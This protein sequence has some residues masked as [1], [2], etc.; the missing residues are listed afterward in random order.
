MAM[1]R[2]ISGSIL[3]LDPT[4][5]TASDIEEYL[6]EHRIIAR[7]A[8]SG[9]C[10]HVEIA[11]TGRRRRVACLDDEG[12][13][14]PGP[15]L[16]DFIESMDNALRKL[17]ID[18]GGRIAWGDIDLGEVDVEGDDFE[19][20]HSAL[21]TVEQ[22]GLGQNTDIT[23]Q[24]ADEDEIEGDIPD[25]GQGPMLAISD[26]SFAALP[27]AA[28]SLETE[29]A[30]FDA[31][32][33][34]AVIADTVPPQAKSMVGSSSFVVAMSADAAGL[35]SP[36]FVVRTDGVRLTWNWS[37]RLQPLPW[38]AAS[39]PARQFAEA[40]LGV[41]AFTCRVAACV[42][43][44]NVEIVRLALIGH[45]SEAPARLAAAFALPREVADCLGGLLPAR[46]IPGAVVFEPK[47]FGARLQSRVAHAVAGERPSD[48]GL[49]K[50][51]RKVNLER[52][53]LTEVLA[54]VQAG[55]GVVALAGGL[56]SWR[57]AGGKI[58]AVLGG[59]F[60]VNAGA[61]ILTVQWIS[62]ALETE[63]L[64]VPR[65]EGPDVP[66]GGADVLDGA[67]GREAG[68]SG[69]EAGGSGLSA[70][71]PASVAG[72]AAFAAGA[73]TASDPGPTADARGPSRRR[74]TYLAPERGG[75]ALVGSVPEGGAPAGGGAGVTDADAGT[76]RAF[77]E[78]AT[79]GS[80][81]GERGEA[82]GVLGAPGQEPPAFVLSDIEARRTFEEL[83]DDAAEG[84]ECD[85]AGDD[86][87]EPDTRAAAVADEF[88]S[89]PE[90]DRESIEAFWTRARNVARIAPL[91]AVMGQDDLSSLCPPAFSFGNTP[92][93]ADRLA[94]LV[95]AGK[96]T[97]TSGWLASYEAA[98]V[99]L[100]SVGDLSIMCDGR[101][102]PR[103]LLSNTDVKVVRFQQAGREISDAEGEGTFEQWKA[104]HDEFF[105]EECRAQ[106]IEYDPAGSIV[107]EYFE[108][109]YSR[110]DEAVRG[111]DDAAGRVTG[112][113]ET[114][115]GD[116]EN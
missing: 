47:P 54:S 56:R 50:M 75:L 102:R 104:S 74:A 106:G 33:A 71:G 90:A 23:G 3:M 95:L 79:S 16:A 92:E 59:A 64:S 34:T 108:V 109:V 97:A 37:D 55:V 113:E 45:P 63:G 5:A 103:A 19:P 20:E 22:A 57:S 86:C 31:C 84:A 7:A 41:G 98:G 4:L 24:N 65:Q 99:D 53:R 48:M 89:V 17:Q 52:P 107:V 66:G 70:G 39:E 18:I 10:F 49:W 93:L 76:S 88:S 83:G 51:Y 78:Q 6:T 61:R 58:L 81:V 96:K 32:G 38:V 62:R 42:P 29:L 110:E 12:G 87:G 35:D 15:S 46:V 85:T 73:S 116:G 26:V 30:A 68:G 8:A 27:G 21:R 2:P 101:G 1:W 82:A 111:A 91:E 28:A 69:R 9:D 114:P 112:S 25:F 72:G 14:V 36:V 13:V 60:V 100:P 80:A 67:A 43:Q 11:V 40:E 77:A 94:D 44:A 115:R 105:A